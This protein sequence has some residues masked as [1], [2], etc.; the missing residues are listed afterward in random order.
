MDVVIV[1]PSIVFGPGDIYRAQ[2]SLVMVQARRHIPVS[3]PGGSNV[4][5]LDDVVAGHLAALECGRTGE[6][7]IL[8][9]ENLTH[10]EL[11]HLASEVTGTPAARL[12][13]PVWMARTLAFLQPIL[14][15]PIGTDEL[16]LA[17]H[18]FYYDIGKSQRELGLP[19]PVPARQALLD[20]YDW[21]KRQ[22]AG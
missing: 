16:G 2:S 8:G 9:G 19:A 4:V 7:Y 3:L 15:L 21:F 22:P 12:V 1:N 10:T 14:R 11:L 18:Y 5:H 17:G 20:A 13:L 6:R